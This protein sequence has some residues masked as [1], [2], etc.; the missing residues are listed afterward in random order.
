[1]R[2]QAH[3][4]AL[5]KETGV[6]HDSVSQFLSLFVRNDHGTEASL[7][8]GCVLIYREREAKAGKDARS[9]NS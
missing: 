9:L 4:S 8:H 6:T 7:A 1:M 2:F 3:S 5:P